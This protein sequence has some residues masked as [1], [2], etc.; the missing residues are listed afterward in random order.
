MKKLFA[1]L[2]LFLPALWL[3]AQDSVQQQEQHAGMRA[4]GKI[5]VVMTVTI[6]ILVGL[7]IYLVRLDRKISKLE[8]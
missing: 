1:S 4:G 8:K 2:V 3:H 5:Y 6:V 7:L